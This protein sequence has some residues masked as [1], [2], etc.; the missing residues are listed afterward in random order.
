[1]SFL[2]KA[3]SDL[4]GNR[5]IGIDLAKKDSQLSVL[6]NDGVEV[7]TLRFPTTRDNVLAL[8]RELRFTDTVALEVTTNATAIARLIKAHS[9][10]AVILSN[11]IKTRVIAEAKVKTDKIDARVLAELAR[12]GYLPTVWLPDDD[13]EAL[14]H[15]FND[16]RSL[17]QRRT[18][19]KNGVHSILHRNLVV[20]DFSDLFNTRG[21]NWLKAAASLE[22]ASCDGDEPD[23]TF[24][25]CPS[26]C[27]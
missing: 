5:F 16:R 24:C 26:A 15:L 27:A 17:V 13:T 3:A 10:A 9:D 7:L 22:T 19:L 14:R 6:N 11:P 4:T 23:S 2:P 25:L 8:A 21:W 12:V 20:Y 1:M 18:E